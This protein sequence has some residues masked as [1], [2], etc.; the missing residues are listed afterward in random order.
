MDSFYT[1]VMADHWNWHGER[2]FSLQARDVLAQVLRLLD[3]SRHREPAFVRAYAVIRP[4][5]DAPM[6]LHQRLRFSYFAARGRVARGEDPAALLWVN[7]TLEIESQLNDTADLAS[8]YFQRGGIYRRMSHLGLAS[9]DHRSALLI[10]SND[11]LRSGFHDTE[12]RML[13]LLQLVGFEFYQG[14]YWEAQQYLKDARYLLPYVPRRSTTV[15]Y[16][17]WMHS[18]LDRWAG[19]SERALQEAR[20][21]ARVF[22]DLGDARSAGRITYHCAECAL[23]IAQRL[24]V[25]GSACDRLLAEAKEHLK[26]ARRLAASGPDENG[27]VLVA[28]GEARWSRI[29][30]R[31]EERQKALEGLLTEARRLH[32][33]VLIAQTYTTLGDEFAMQEDRESANT[34]YRAAL[35]ALEGTDSPAAGVW[36][37]RSLRFGEEWLVS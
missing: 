22:V 2:N 14:H 1:L 28:L 33:E 21:A 15:A 18:L 17:S 35:D 20:A 13:V 34:C 9:R 12:F 16:M 25:H 8:L 5:L 10:L 37:W 30:R 27:M 26:A 29:A 3:R 36:A 32:D 7:K 24:D 11:V 19:H 23:D 4:F 6:S 31:D